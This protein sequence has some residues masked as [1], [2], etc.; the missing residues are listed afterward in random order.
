MGFLFILGMLFSLLLSA[1]QIS[2]PG[3]TA[4]VYIFQQIM[5]QVGMQ[6]IMV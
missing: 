4:L 6:S 3:L 2:M 5:E 1:E